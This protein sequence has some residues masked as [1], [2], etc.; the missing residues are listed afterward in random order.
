MKNKLI[1]IGEKDGI[2]GGICN[3]TYYP[4]ALTKTQIDFSYNVLKLKNPPVI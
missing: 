1:T 4:S 3:V 2:S